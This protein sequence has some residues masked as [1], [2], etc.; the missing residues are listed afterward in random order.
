MIGEIAVGSHDKKL[1]LNGLQRYLVAEL[2]KQGS[3][4][5][6]DWQAVKTAREWSSSLGHKNQSRVLSLGQGLHKINPI[7]R[8]V[9]SLQPQNQT[10]EGINDSSAAFSHFCSSFLPIITLPLFLFYHDSQHQL[11]MQLRWLLETWRLPQR[12]LPALLFWGQVIAF[13]LREQ[14]T[15]NLLIDQLRRQMPD[16]SELLASVQ[17]SVATLI[18]LS[19]AIASWQL[20]PEQL[21]MAVA[22]YSF[23]STPED[24]RLSILRSQQQEK[25]IPGVSALTGSLSGAYNSTNGIPINWYQLIKNHSVLKGYTNQINILFAKWSGIYSPHKAVISA[26]QPVASGGTIQARPHWRMI[27]QSID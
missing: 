13:I 1:N 23:L 20:P 22:L 11:E 2:I 27:S 17:Q 18:P 5:S 3:I 9:P 19:Q 8:A 25:I 26:Q 24:L 10:N 12:R 21:Q 6:I 15:L 7:E 14:F 4:E 16:F